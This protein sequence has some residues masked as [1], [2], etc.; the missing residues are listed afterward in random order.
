MF[1]YIILSIS[2]ILP[3]PPPQST[4]SRKI[5]K[6]EYIE[7]IDWYGGVCT[8]QIKYAWYCKKDTHECI[9]SNDRKW[10]E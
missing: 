7:D 4:F 8:G 10:C 9:D 2:L 5:T 3:L 1:K 6:C